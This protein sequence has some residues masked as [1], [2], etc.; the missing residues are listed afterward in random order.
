MVDFNNETTI[1][2][3]AIDIE[4]VI[5][6]QRRHDTIEAF[7]GYNKLILSGAQAS[8]HNFRSRVM[9]LYIEL[10]ASLERHYPEKNKDP[11][12][13]SYKDLHKWISKDSSSEDLLK[14]F[15]F[16]NK[17]LDKIKLTRLDTQRVYD[18]TRVETENRE[19]KL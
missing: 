15:R 19:K 1:T 6:L 13:P 12:I 14:G 2:R 16:I 11:E 10:E 8:D 7:E 9:S 17:F 3:P 18:S 4:R 5:V